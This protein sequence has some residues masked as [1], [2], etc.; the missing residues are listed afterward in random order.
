MLHIYPRIIITQCQ[1]DH[2]TNMCVCHVAITEYNELGTSIT[3]L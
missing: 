3:V 1:N 2:V